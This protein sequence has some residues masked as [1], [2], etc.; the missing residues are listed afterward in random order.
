[1][2]CTRAHSTRVTH[3][4]KPTTGE[5]SNTQAATLPATVCWEN[6]I[7][8]SS[9]PWEEPKPVRSTYARAPPS[10]AVGMPEAVAAVT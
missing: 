8:C 4:A 10:G 2:H 9:E 1:V 7:I 3:P 5:I 6:S